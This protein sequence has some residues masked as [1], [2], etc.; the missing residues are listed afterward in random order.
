MIL[1][2]VNMNLH[3]LLFWE[4][5]H[6]TE[7]DQGYVEEDLFGSQPCGKLM[8]AAVMLSCNMDLSKLNFLVGGNVKLIFNSKL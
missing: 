5:S 7:D 6:E 8:L 2:N 1:V 4:M 3:N